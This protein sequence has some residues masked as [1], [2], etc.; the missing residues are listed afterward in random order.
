MAITRARS[1]RSCPTIP[2]PSWSTSSSSIRAATDTLPELVEII[3]RYR[4]AHVPLYFEGGI[5]LPYGENP[6]TPE[7]AKA[8]VPILDPTTPVNAGVARQ[9][10][11]TGTCFN[12]KPDADGNCP[13][14]ALK[15]YRDL[16]PN[17]PPAR[18]TT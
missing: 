6:I 16:Y 15:V 2:K 13:S 12:V 3:H 18:S 1:A 8:G 7:I 5:N 9:Y 10:N 4:Q 14:L 17:E 11:A